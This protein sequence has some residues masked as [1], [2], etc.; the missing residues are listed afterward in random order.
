RFQAQEH[1]PMPLEQ[2]V[3]DWEVIGTTQTD[4]GEP[5]LS[6]VVAA[7]RRDMIERLLAALRAGDLR[8]VGI[9]VAAFGLIRAIARDGHLAAAQPSYEERASAEQGEAAAAPQAPQVPARML[10][11]LG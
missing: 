7:A 3:L 5:Q 4:T 1:V 10:C 8:P 2:A 6:V 9:D 11:Y